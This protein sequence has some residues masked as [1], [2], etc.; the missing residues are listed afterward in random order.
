[1]STNFPTSLDSWPVIVDN[2]TTI[3]VSYINNIQDAVEALEAK[4]GIDGVGDGTKLD[5]KISKF[6]ESDSPRKV[7]FYNDTA[8]TNW[9]VVS[10]VG[11]KIVGLKG[12]ATYSTGGASAGAWTI[13]GWENNTHTHRY[14]Y[15]SGDVSYT[16]TSGG[17]AQA[18]T[19]YG[20]TA[21]GARGL[22]M[23]VFNT[24]C[25]G[26]WY[27]MYVLTGTYAYVQDYTHTH[28]HAGS[29]RPAGAVGILAQFDG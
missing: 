12:G 16:Y 22:M 25:V 9:S 20:Y 11:G 7:Y 8:P 13:T 2:T 5:Y 24:W 17:S 18:M 19:T 27:L 1:M 29:W 15:L 10:A 14:Y 28:S 23:R 4:V 6:W 3:V 26:S 21:E